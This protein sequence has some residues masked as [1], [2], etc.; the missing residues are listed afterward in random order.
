MLRA[1]NLDRRD[2]IRLLLHSSDA[3][4]LTVS[5]NGLAQPIID[6]PWLDQR[7]D[8]RLTR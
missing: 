3:R 6:R 5:A 2:A 4:S 1:Q 8:E 7:L